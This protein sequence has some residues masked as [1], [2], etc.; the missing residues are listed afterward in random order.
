[1]KEMAKLNDEILYY[2]ERIKE[3]EKKVYD[4]RLSRLIL[5]DILESVEKRRQEEIK[6]LLKQNRI[7][8]EKN[9]QYVKTIW[10]L[11][12]NCK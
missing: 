5:M 10:S 8:R 7:L 2:K 4:L 11:R 9:Q 1:V 12:E 3:L 6:D